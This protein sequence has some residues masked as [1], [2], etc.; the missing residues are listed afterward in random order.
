MLIF[1]I[2]TKFEVY[3]ALPTQASFVQS[4]PAWRRWRE[5]W[6]SARTVKSTLRPGQPHISRFKIV[7][8]IDLL[9]LDLLSNNFPTSTH[10]NQIT[11]EFIQE[12]ITNPR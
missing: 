4:L 11:P 8:I 2:S 12:P 5:A 9:P 7:S 1:S 3:E 6:A 10:L